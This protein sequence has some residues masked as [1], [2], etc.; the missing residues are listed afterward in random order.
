MADSSDGETAVD[1]EMLIGAD[2]YWAITTGHT[3]RGDS[4]SVAIQTKLGWILSERSYS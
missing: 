1:A 2:Y 3:R 4:G